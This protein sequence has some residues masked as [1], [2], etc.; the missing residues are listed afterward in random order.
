MVGERFWVICR[1][2]VVGMVFCNFGNFVWMLLIVW[3]I[4]VFGSLWIISK[5]VGLVLVILV[6]CIFCIE[7]VIVVILFR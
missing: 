6:L 4:L 5:I 2:I 1:L 7:L 3:I